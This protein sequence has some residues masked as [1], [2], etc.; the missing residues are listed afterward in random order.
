LE[1]PTT[2]A[3]PAAPEA[4]AKQTTATE[5]KS[6]P[7]TKP[8]PQATKPDDSFKSAINLEIEAELMEKAEAEVEDQK[9]SSDIPKII[10][11]ESAK[12]EKVETIPE[13]ILKI[14]E[15]MKE[16]SGDADK[17]II[18]EISEENVAESVKEGKSENLKEIV[19]EKTV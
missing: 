5:Q 12:P 16:E 8:K 9:A 15:I 3:A 13:R 18:A 7:K 1:V 2:S 17:T 14:A 6:K 4:P 11:E 10:A 19:L